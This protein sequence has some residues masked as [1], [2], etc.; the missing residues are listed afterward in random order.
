MRKLNWLDLG[1]YEKTNCD[2]TN[3]YRWIGG[4]EPMD[5]LKISGVKR[6]DTVTYQVNLDEGYYDVKKEEFEFYRINP[7]TFVKENGLWK[8]DKIES[9]KWH[10]H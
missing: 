5:T 9:N 4:Q 6:I 10:L 1:D 7:V 8:I 2:F 3:Y